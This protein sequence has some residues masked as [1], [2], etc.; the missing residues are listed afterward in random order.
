[1]ARV[2]V[3]AMGLLIGAAA[4]AIL[5]VTTIVW[6]AAGLALVL[7]SPT[8]NDVVPALIFMGSALAFN[9]ASLLALVVVAYGGL[10]M[11]R[12]DGQGW[13]MGGAITQIVW[14]VLHS[15]MILYTAFGLGCLIAP[16]ELL[17]GLTTGTMALVALAHSDVQ[18]AFVALKH[19]PDLIETSAA[20]D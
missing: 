15:M 7:Q 12:V 1:M 3:P 13:A 11:L 14:V 6:P 16:I 17:I 2:R 19:H 5:Y 18:R 9:T 10:R 4:Q 8:G 20:V